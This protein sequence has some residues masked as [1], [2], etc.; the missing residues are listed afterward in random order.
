MMKTGEESK[1]E[2]T[3]TVIGNEDTALMAEIRPFIFDTRFDLEAQPEP[4]PEELIEEE[5]PEEIVPTF[6][7]E[8]MKTAQAA[9]KGEFAIVA[10]GDCR[11]ECEAGGSKRDM[12]LLWQ[13]IDEIVERNLS[14]ESDEP[15]IPLESI[16]EISEETVEGTMDESPEIPDAP[17]QDTPQD[18]LG[19]AT[20]TDHEG[21]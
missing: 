15:E 18:T 8:E 3:A 17:P 7:E 20:T 1:P 21:T 4:E 6:S 16:E 5:E 13:E 14:G 2:T 9:F 10:A 12:D 11:V 19:D